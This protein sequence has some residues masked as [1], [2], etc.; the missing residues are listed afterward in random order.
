MI[1]PSERWDGITDVEVDIGDTTS[2]IQNGSLKIKGQFN[3]RLGFG[4]KVTLMS[5]PGPNAME[6]L[7]GA[8][9][10]ASSDTSGTVRT[11]D[12]NTGV[13]TVLGTSIAPAVAGA[14]LVP[15][16][17]K[18]YVAN[19]GIAPSVTT[20]SAMRAT[21]LT[22]P[23]TVPTLTI[24]AGTAPAVMSVGTHLARYRYYNSTLGLLSNPSPSV[25]FVIAANQAITVF[26][27][28]APPAGSVTRY[29]VTLAGATTFYTSTSLTDINRTDDFVSLLVPASRDGEYGHSPIPSYGLLLEHR[30]R[31]FAWDSATSLLAW[32]QPGFSESFDTTALARVITLSGSDTP[33]AMFSFYS[34]LYLCGQFGMRRMVY[35]SDPA[36]AMVVPTLGNLGAYSQRCVVSGAAGEVYGWGRNGMWRIN[37]MQPEKISWQV[38]DT[39]ALYVDPAKI[40]ERFVVYDPIDQ[41]VLF[42]FCLVGSTYANA[43]F[44]YHIPDGQWIYYKYRNSFRAGCRNGQLNPRQV[45]ALADANGY[46][47][48]VGSAQADGAA[49]NIVTV[50]GGTTTTTIFGANTSTPGQYAY[51]DSSGESRLITVSGGTSF[52]VSPGFTTAPALGTLI[53]VGSI[54]QRWKTMWYIASQFQNKER[55]QYLLLNIIP[56][57][58]MGTGKV[59]LTRDFSDTYISMTAG[60]SDTWPNGVTIV[61]GETF[62]RVDFDAGATD[63]Y[64][65]IP[66]QTEW[67]RAIRVE[68][69]VDNAGNGV[70]WF[71]YQF[72]TSDKWQDQPVVRE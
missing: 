6:E 72:A 56:N 11:T 31:M 46:I 64:L 52:Q 51:Q 61:N 44:A 33:T 10:T 9:I 25:S 69:V 40:T 50:G 32:S 22:A 60:S 53:Q 35:T 62:I 8:M 42:F 5:A 68:V 49:A 65:A 63:G 21:G 2:F 20:A 58:V 13:V 66:L 71:D 47:W 15:A 19:Q 18:M 28:V 59:Y 70:Q 27:V 54:E 39:L 16:F 36:G 17:G 24:A 45:L 3:R 67:A 41:Q 4:A 57:T 29:E 12:Q 34:D 48:R 55:P 7:A 30:Q 43:A 38:D 23:A 14:N 1:N 37:S 26:S